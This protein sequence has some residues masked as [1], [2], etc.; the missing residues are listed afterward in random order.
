MS[1][2]NRS[3]ETGPSRRALL[4]AA[5]TLGALAQANLGFSEQIQQAAA[6]AIK[7]L[8]EGGNLGVLGA[9]ENLI[10]LSRVPTVLQRI[11]ARQPPG[12]QRRE[13][14]QVLGFANFASQNLSLSKNVLSTVG[15]PI[16]VQSTLLHGRR[17]PR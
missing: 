6:K 7:L 10:G 13:L 9:P 1:K 4:V 14:E 17:T 8:L 12:R 3:F 5:A 11:V 15:Q 16:Q 2:R